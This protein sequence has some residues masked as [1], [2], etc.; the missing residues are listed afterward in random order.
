MVGIRSVSGHTKKMRQAH[1]N[2]GVKE[3]EEDHE[4]TGFHTETKRNRLRMQW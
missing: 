3:N 2:Q 4:F 1:H